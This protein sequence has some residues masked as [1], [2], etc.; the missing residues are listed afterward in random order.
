MI[1]GLYI[2]ASGML[3]E[4]KKMNVL[5]NNIVNSDTY[6]YKSDKLY[7]RSFGDMVLSRVDSLD[8][9]GTQ[10]QI[11][12]LSAGIH[13][14][15][16][17]TIFGQGSMDQTG[18]AT[19]LAI[20]GDGFFTVQ[21]PNGIRYTRNG[22]FTVS[23]GKLVTAEGY[24]VMGN[25]GAIEV[26][27]GNFTVNGSGEVLVNDAVAD[28]LKI[29]KFDNTDSLSKEGDCYFVNSGVEPAADTEST[30][31]QGYLETSDVD[32]ADT[33]VEVIKVSRLYE[34]NQRVVSAIDETLQKAV[35]EIGSV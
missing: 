2:A 27:D 18:L 4:R 8:L 20:T 26:K 25:N 22:N 19:D 5:V 29:V 23:D 14:D 3:T 12:S 6:G 9:A 1:R 32:L 11:G 34:A 17:Y 21:T 13:A 10:T 7:S 28:Q 24:S 15:E 31:N 16:V 30:I 33:M 35:T